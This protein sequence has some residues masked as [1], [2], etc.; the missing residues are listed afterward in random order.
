[1][2]MLLAHDTFVTLCRSGFQRI[3]LSSRRFASNLRRMLKTFGKT[4]VGESENYGTRLAAQLIL[5]C[6]LRMTTLL[7]VRYD[8]S[9]ERVGSELTGANS[10]SMT[11]AERRTRIN[12]T[13]QRLVPVV[14]SDARQPLETPED[15]E[16]DSEDELDT[17]LIEEVARVSSLT[18]I[19]Q[20]IKPSRAFQGL[21]DSL[22][23]FLRPPR[24]SEVVVSDATSNEGVSGTGQLPAPMD[25]FDPSASPRYAWTDDSIPVMGVER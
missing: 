22:A 5:S 9:Y 19:E 16:S 2:E 7:R 12:K 3:D 13:I 4:L 10:R 18:E 20:F 14:A 24:P 25:P 11:E 8:A 17:T 6:S 15:D 1:M 23:S 21:M